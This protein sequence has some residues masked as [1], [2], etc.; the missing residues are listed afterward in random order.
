MIKLSLPYWLSGIELTKLKDAAQEW[1]SRVG[2]WAAW[3]LTQLNALECDPGMLEL[4]A[5]QRDITRY[6]GEPLELFR[7]R[8]HYAYINARDAGS[9]IGFINICHRLGIGHFETGERQ[10][11]YDWDIINIYLE[12]DQLSDN[13]E[14]LKEIIRMYGRT[15]RR[16]NFILETPVPVYLRCAASGY[17][18][19]TISA[20]IQNPGIR[21]QIHS[22]SL[23]TTVTVASLIK[24]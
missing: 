3:P 22:V 7:K 16:Y 10:A 1:F 15:C 9:D 21:S 12:D 8:V 17:T 18:T 20:S 14:L 24:D 13:P 11:G 6:S 23:N 19:E 5:W 4:I 2:E